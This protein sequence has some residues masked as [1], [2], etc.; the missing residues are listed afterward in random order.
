MLWGITVR[1]DCDD[2]Q[3]DRAPQ[4]DQDI[5]GTHVLMD[6]A[7]HREDAQEICD[8]ASALIEGLCAYDQMV[9]FATNR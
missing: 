4:R 7:R 1:I 6:T 8:V 5:M 9:E 3:L 2:F